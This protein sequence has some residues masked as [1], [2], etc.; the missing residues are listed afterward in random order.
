MSEVLKDIALALVITALV[1]GL[2]ALVLLIPSK[3]ESN[4]INL[5]QDERFI[6]GYEMGYAAGSRN[7]ID[8]L[9]A[10]RRQQSWQD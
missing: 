2:V 6:I 3:S 4:E 8:S 7:C 1:Y 10:L 5:E 9:N